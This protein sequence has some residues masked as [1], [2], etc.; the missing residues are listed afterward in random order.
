F[1]LVAVYLR[2]WLQETPIFIEMQARKALAEE[3]PLKSVVINHKREV[4]V[5]MLLTWLLSAGIV[6]VILMTPTYLQKQFA[7]APAL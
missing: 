1:G 6:V 2:R 4:A 3:L 7:I 5:S